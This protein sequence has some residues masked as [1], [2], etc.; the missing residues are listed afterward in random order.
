MSSADIAISWSGGKDSALALH[1]ILTSSRYH[2]K[3]VSELLTTVTE[4]YERVSGHGIHLDI[5]RRQAD[6]VRHSLDIA[7]IPQATTMPEY[8]SVMCDAYQ[9]LRRSGTETVAFGD[10]FLKGPKKAHLGALHRAEMHGVFP[11]WGQ[12]SRISVRRFIQLGYKAIVVCVNSHI[13]D[14]SYLGRVIDEQFLHDLPVN[15]DPSGENGEYHTFVVDGPLWNQAVDCIV[16]GVVA[17]DEQ[18]FCD[19]RL[20]G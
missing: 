16:A 5:L 8:E 14:E 2:G 7:Y 10:I 4:G 15:V 18:L 9:R 17:R 13:L 11:L 12:N 19:V 1:E 3:Q 6:C 20:R